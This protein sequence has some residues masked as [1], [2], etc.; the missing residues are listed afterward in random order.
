MAL[1]MIQFNV[2]DGYVNLKPKC[3]VHNSFGVSIM[4]HYKSLASYI[5]T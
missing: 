5:W 3:W 2:M 4:V 1:I